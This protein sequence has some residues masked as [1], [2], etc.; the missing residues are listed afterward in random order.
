MRLEKSKELKVGDAP[1]DVPKTADIQERCVGLK[2]W[3]NPG[4]KFYVARLHYSANPTK[5]GK[6]WKDTTRAGYTWSEWMREY[7]IV[8]SSF[9]GVPVYID[10]YSRAFHVSLEPLVWAKELP[11]VRGWDFG[12]GAN[13]MACIWAQLISN[14]RLMVYKELTATDTSI[15][16]FA[17]AVKQK[18]LEWFP[19][20]GKWFDVV[21]P[22]GFNRSQ[23]DKRACTDVIRATL[24]TKPQP[25]EK[26]IPKRRK[27]VVDFLKA[28]VRG[29]P[30]VFIDLAGCPM[31]V[32]G[33][34]GGYHY[35]YA[36]DGQLRDDPEKNEWSHPHDAFQMICSRVM[37][38]D[39]SAQEPIKIA[40][41]RYA[42][43]G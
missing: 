11:I 20:T 2:T 35:A 33:F 29:L 37:Y 12:L 23:L 31:L 10:D 8:F 34:D 30:K 3:R 27:A 43:G 14:Y 40:T 21:D 16:N 13:G 6:E 22:S 42:F 19:G 41:P 36:R 1:E 32:E 5:R 17:E 7:E 15:E 39:F 24:H 28:N 38:L 26:A 9:E 4:N 25:G 18:S